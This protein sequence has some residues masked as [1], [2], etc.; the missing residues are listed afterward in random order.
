MKNE[1]ITCSHCNGQKTFK[2]IAQH[3]LGAGHD[4]PCSKCKGAGVVKAPGTSS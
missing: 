4:V 3:R 2:T 1:T